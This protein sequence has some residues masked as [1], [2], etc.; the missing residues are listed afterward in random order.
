MN[1]WTN[2]GK[3]NEKKMYISM[4]EWMIEDWMSKI[5]ILLLLF[6]YNRCFV[7]AVVVVGFFFYCFYDWD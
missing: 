6:Y 2:E 1:E 4:H 7:V 3:N 5:S